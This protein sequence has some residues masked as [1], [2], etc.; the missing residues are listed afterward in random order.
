MSLNVHF[1][2]NLYVKLIRLF[3]YGNAMI[4]LMFHKKAFFIKYSSLSARYCEQ[5]ASF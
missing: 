4:N 2:I 3:L 5:S 1:H